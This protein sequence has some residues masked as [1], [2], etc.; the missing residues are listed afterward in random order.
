MHPRRV[1]RNARN[2]KNHGRKKRK[3]YFRRRRKLPIPQKTRE[4]TSSQRYLNDIFR[5]SDSE[6][7]SFTNEQITAT[8]NHEEERKYLK[9]K[10]KHTNTRSNKQ[11]TQSNTMTRYKFC[12]MV[13]SVSLYC[14]STIQ[15][16]TDFHTMNS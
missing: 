15:Y 16:S 10:T 5:D 13:Q 9:N 7:Y 4:V 6:S 3:D 8:H 12:I 14:L 11:K 1:T 2:K